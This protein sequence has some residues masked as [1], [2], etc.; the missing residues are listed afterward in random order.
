MLQK[1]K[2]SILIRV[3]ISI[4]DLHDAKLGALYPFNMDRLHGRLPG[5][6]RKSKLYSTLIVWQL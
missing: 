5:L 2:K 3:Q 1:Q 4:G 6:I